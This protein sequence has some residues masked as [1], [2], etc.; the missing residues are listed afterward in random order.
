MADLYKYTFFVFLMIV[1]LACSLI[2]IPAAP[3][4]N[5]QASPTLESTATQASAA[6]GSASIAPAPTETIPPTDTPDPALSSIPLPFM[7]MMGIG[8]FFNPVGQ[9]V[10]TWHDG[11]IMPQVTSGQDFKSGAVYSF[12]ATATISQG[13]SFYETK[14]P[15]LGYLLYGG[16]GTGSAGTGS[17]AMHN[18]F[19][20]WYKGSQVFLIYIT[21]Y[22]SNPNQVI[23]VLSTQ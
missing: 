15:K 16:P 22:D 2:T 4:T 5:I 14:M 8:Q 17:N 13:V 9:P 3:T 7:N 6:T 21:S 18:S 1:S 11:N 23:V 19:L 12:R 20:D 10:Q